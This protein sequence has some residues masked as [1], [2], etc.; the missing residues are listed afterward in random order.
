MTVKLANLFGSSSKSSSNSMGNATDTV[1]GKSSHH[2]NGHHFQ[3]QSPS[4]NANVKL[5]KCYDH[6]DDRPAA[7][8]IYGHTYGCNVEHMDDYDEQSLSSTC[9]QR[10]HPY[11][12]S[13]RPLLD[14]CRPQLMLVMAGGKKPS[15]QTTTGTPMSPLPPKHN[16]T[17]ASANPNAA[18]YVSPYV[19]Q[20]KRDSVKG[21]HGFNDFDALSQQYNQ[22][23]QSPHIGYPYGS[24]PS[25]T[26]QPS[27]FCFDRL[28]REQ[29]ITAN[30][31]TSST[32]T[33]KSNCSS[34]SATD[35]S[36][37]RYGNVNYQ[38]V[39]YYLKKSLAQPL[40]H[41]VPHPHYLPHSSRFEEDFCTRRNVGFEGSQ[42]EA[43][44][45]AAVSFKASSGP[46]IFGI[47][48]E[49]QRSDYGRGHCTNNTN[50]STY[51]N[52]TQ[53]NLNKPVINATHVKEHNALVPIQM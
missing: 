24:P 5:I 20:Q 15:T 11:N 40:S 26:V 45:S 27:D 17:D 39:A 1:P 18:A 22:H 21:L 6:H 32:A 34:N 41:T 51:C 50:T 2:Y 14:D 47:S 49:D 3:Q 7:M 19:Q 23:L 9:M 25:P 37:L 52:N 8:T 29:C 4:P 42:V 44:G 16:V 28:Q 35:C 31:S 10:N 43:V 53:N 48:H 36:P 12:S 30:P 38:D 46:F 33:M 13:Q